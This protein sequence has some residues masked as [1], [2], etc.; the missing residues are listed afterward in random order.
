MICAVRDAFTKAY[1]VL[2]VCTL[3]EFKRELR[4]R[5]AGDIADALYE[6]AGWSGGDDQFGF[7]WLPKLRMDSPG[8]VATFMHEITHLVRRRMKVCRLS[9][10]ETTAY[11]TEYLVRKLLTKYKKELKKT[12]TEAKRRSD[13]C[14]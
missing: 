6:A 8:D 12:G 14:D 7:I 11:Y 10:D 1:I 9:G 4:A 3:A 13:P 2:A 5:G